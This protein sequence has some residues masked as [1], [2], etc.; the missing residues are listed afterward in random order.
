MS[1]KY[2]KLTEAEIQKQIAADPDDS[3]VT[4]AEAKHARPF[5]EVFPDLYESIKRSRGRPPVENAK[6]AVT[7]R[8]DPRILEKYQAKGKD[9]RSRMAQV[10]ED[11][12]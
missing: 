3:D 12:I 6:A 9:W 8:I 10:L 7:L 5:A 2:K 11:G 4:E 1:T